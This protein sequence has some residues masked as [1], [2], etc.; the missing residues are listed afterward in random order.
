MKKNERLWR[1]IKVEA[2]MLE[3]DDLD[4]S[5]PKELVKWTGEMF[6]AAKPIVRKEIRASLEK[7]LKIF[8]A[9]DYKARNHRRIIVPHP[10][11]EIAAKQIIGRFLD[12]IKYNKWLGLETAYPAM[13]REW[14]DKFSR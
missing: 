7:V 10:R 6:D 5:N 11:R 4:F 3:M 13:V 1:K 8:E 9:H 12:A 2:L 14:Q